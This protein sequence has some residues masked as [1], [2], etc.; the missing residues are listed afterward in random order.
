MSRKSLFLYTALGLAA[1]MVT[2]AIVAPPLAV[3]PVGFSVIYLPVLF[4]SLLLAWA[5]PSVAFATRWATIALVAGIFLVMGSPIAAIAGALLTIA[6]YSVHRRTNR[7]K[8]RV[9]AETVDFP[10]VEYAYG[11]MQVQFATPIETAARMTP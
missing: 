2:L 7:S 9:T 6:V 10:S 11:G 3:V 4:V 8:P 5:L 1:F